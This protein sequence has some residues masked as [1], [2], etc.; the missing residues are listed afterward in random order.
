MALL[1][2]SANQ[3]QLGLWFIN[4]ADFTVRFYRLPCPEKKCK[5]NGQRSINALQNRTVKSNV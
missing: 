5:T 4:T 3:Y 1:A 2:N